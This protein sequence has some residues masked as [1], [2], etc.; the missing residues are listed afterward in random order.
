MLLETE[1][2]NR[3]I[4]KKTINKP[5]TYIIDQLKDIA[6][7]KY[8]QEKPIGYK[9]YYLKNK[10]YKP[11]RTKDNITEAEEYAN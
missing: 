1:P 7:G 9:E 4:P 3:D 10:N 5:D 2:Y 11:V 8:L 6:N